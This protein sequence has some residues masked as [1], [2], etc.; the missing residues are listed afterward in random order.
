[1]SNAQNLTELEALI[2]DVPEFDDWTD[3]MDDYEEEILLDV[4]ERLVELRDSLDASSRD[5]TAV[6]KAIGR[7]NKRLDEATRVDY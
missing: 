3:P 6:E 1:M 5:Y 4:E 7:I 2:A